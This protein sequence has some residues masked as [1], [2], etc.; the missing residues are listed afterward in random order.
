[1]SDNK[2]TFSVAV[3][4]ISEEEQHVLKSTF[5][6]S[7]SRPRT[8]VLTNIAS[9]KNADILIVNGD[10][11]AAMTEWRAFRTF[12]AD[13]GNAPPAVLAV[14]EDPGD[15]KHFYIQRPLLATRVLRVLD[16]VTIKA[17]GFAPELT[18]GQE[19]VYEDDEALQDIKEE[20]EQKGK[21]RYSALVVDDSLPIRKQMEVE[22]K[23]FETKAD[24]AET[25][26]RALEMVNQELYDIIFLDIVLPGI[27]GYQVCKEIK[28]DPTKKRTPV[29]MLT[30]KSSPFDRVKGSLA[31]CDTYLT[32]PLTHETFQKIV[33]R[34]LQ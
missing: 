18:I 14:T 7:E 25:G 13:K 11:D 3:I 23:L 32:K 31:G 4:G 12:Q 2:R 16:K 19:E 24:F 17:L 29:I 8:Y 10:D 21:P 34:Y 1:M 26:E 33:K 9:K 5:W 27:D 6:L 22:L 28:K 30:S 15:S 20:I